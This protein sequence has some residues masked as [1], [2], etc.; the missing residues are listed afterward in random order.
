M[1][2]FQDSQDP[3][4]KL[5]TFS[6]PVFDELVSVVGDFNGWD[7]TANPLEIAGDAK[8]TSIELEAG[9]RYQFRYLGESG[10]WFNDDSLSDYAEN[11][12]GALNGCFEV[13]T[14]PLQDAMGAEN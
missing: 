14:G 11:D 7:P 10:E 13:P 6:L 3:M 2:Q 5:V 8:T 12:F 1:I 9:A 4:R